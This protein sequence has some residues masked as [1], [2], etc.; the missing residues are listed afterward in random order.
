MELS[1]NFDLDL[2]LPV[3]LLTTRL[4]EYDWDYQSPQKSSRRLQD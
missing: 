4:M 2:L 1:K 3:P